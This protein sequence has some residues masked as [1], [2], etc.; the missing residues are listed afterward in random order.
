MAGLPK[1]GLQMK[2][3]IDFKLLSILSLIVLVFFALSTFAVSAKKEMVEEWIDAEE[4]GSITLEDLTIIFDPGVLKK[5]T[6]IHI[7]YFGDGEYQIGPE[8]K[9]NGTFTL[10]FDNLPTV[11]MTFKQ[12]EWVELTCIDGYVETNHFSRYRGC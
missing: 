5:D 6:K 2:K 11:V 9:V 8:I 1:E 10:Y 3:R 4:G 7:I 12:G